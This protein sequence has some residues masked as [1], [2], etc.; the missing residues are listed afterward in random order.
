MGRYAHRPACLWFDNLYVRLT[1]PPQIARAHGLRRAAPAASVRV[2]AVRRPAAIGAGFVRPAAGRKRIRPE[3]ARRRRRAGRHAARHPRALARWRA[4]RGERVGEIAFRAHFLRF[5]ARAHLFSARFGP[6][7]PAKN[8][9]PSTHRCSDLRFCC[10]A[11]STGARCTPPERLS[12]QRTSKNVREPGPRR[13]ACNEPQKMRNPA[14]APPPQS[15]PADRTRASPASTV[16]EPARRFKLKVGRVDRWRSGGDSAQP[17]GS[18]PATEAN[19]GIRP[20]RRVLFFARVE[21]WLQKSEFCIG[22]MPSCGR[23]EGGQ[24]PTDRQK[25]SSRILGHGRCGT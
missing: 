17:L 23:H 10:A 16:A 6:P 15:R 3:S 5:V 24:P 8:H 25:P 9:D 18:N 22:L 11:S 20:A 1:N 14:P 7:P 4:A 21:F 12:L 13:R 19:G 2:A